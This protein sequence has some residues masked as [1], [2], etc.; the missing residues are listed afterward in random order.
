[1]SASVCD[2][3]SYIVSGAPVKPYY[4]PF[5]ALT[6]AGAPNLLV[7]G[8]SIS[9]TFFANAAIRLHPEEWVTGVAAGVAAGEMLARGWAST[10]EALDNVAIVQASIEAMGSPLEWTLP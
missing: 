6:V 10:Q 8:K 1:V 3:P 9:S 5:R 2:Y 4:L 7:V